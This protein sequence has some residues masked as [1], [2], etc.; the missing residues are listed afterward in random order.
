MPFGNPKKCFALLIIIF[1]IALPLAAQ[2]FYFDIGMGIGGGWTK[3]DGHDVKGVL[4]DAGY[5][6]SSL[7]VSLGL[8]AGYGPF[9]SVPLYLVGAFN[10]MGHRLYDGGSYIQFNSYMIGPGLIFYPGKNL[11][12][13]AD[14]GFS[15]TGNTTNV[16][17]YY[18]YNSAHA[19]FAWDISAAVDVGSDSNGC[20]IGLRYFGSSNTLKTSGAKE[21]SSSLTFFIRYAHRKRVSKQRH[22]NSD[23][24]AN[25][26]PEPAGNTSVKYYISTDRTI[27]S[28]PFAIS[29]LK[30]MAKEGHITRDTLVWKSGMNGWK[31]AGEVEELSVL[32]K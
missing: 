31:R 27:Y 12:L 32:W 21:L 29:H 22:N 10:G 4:S 11:Q 9:G 28:G 13:A 20:L 15:W 24:T 1:G 23:T 16:D 5:D 3:V 7:A 19:G 8:K 25:K 18:V 14:L 17:G 26:V 2:G 30:V 6:P